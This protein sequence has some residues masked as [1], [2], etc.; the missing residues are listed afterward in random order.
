M[1]NQRSF[2]FWSMILLGINGI[3]GS[4]IFLLPGQVMNL[5]GSWSLFVYFG[6]TLLILSIAWCF[7]QCAALFD[8]NGGAYVYAKAAFGDFIGFEIG[9]MRWVVGIIAW[10][11]LIVGFVTALSSVWSPALEEPIRSLLI[12]GII[13]GLGII[14][15]F[16]MKFFK[17]FNNLVTVT[18]IIPLILFILLGFFYIEIDHYASPRW[19]EFE[20]ESFGS[21]ALIILYSF[22][23][24]ETLVVAAGEMQNP[25]KNLP[26]VVMLVISFCS[27][28]YF[29]IQFIAIGVLGGALAESVTPLGDVAQK[30]L[31][32]SGKWLVTLAMLISIGGVNL[33]ASF[34]TPRSGVALAEDGM[35]PKWIASKGRHGTPIWAI[36]LTTSFTA[37]LAITGNFTE[38]V[39]ISVVSRFAQYISTCVAT[40]LLH[41]K[42]DELK[43][44]GKHW[45]FILIPIVGLCGVCW[46]MFQATWFQLICG[47]GALIIGIPL[48]WMRSERNKSDSVPQTI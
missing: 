35:M 13:S 16:G 48:Y 39:I 21:A 8:R 46:L 40:Y 42:S 20:M 15:I 4:G 31:G 12:L 33:Y 22:G 27:F 26:F 10:A 44:N 45:R 29:I 23:G 1:D 5:A 43:Q 37:L 14:N 25:Q 38:L 47:L 41:R 17:Y 3:I 34:I 24:F 6:V 11:S 7:S 36:L 32:D 9:L 28:L 30:L 18:K 19:E 2:D